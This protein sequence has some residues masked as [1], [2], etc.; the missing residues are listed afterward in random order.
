MEVAELHDRH[1]VE[2]EVAARLRMVDLRDDRAIVMVVRPISR[3]PPTR[4]SPGLG[5]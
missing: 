1:Y 4:R 5:P 2:L 3:R